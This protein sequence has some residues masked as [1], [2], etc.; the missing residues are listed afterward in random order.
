[1]PKLIDWSVRFDLMREAVVRLAASGGA[2]AV[3]LSAVAAELQVSASTL[4]RTLRSPDVLP[5]MGV[6]WIERQRRYPRFRGRPNGVEHGSIEHATWVISRELPTDEEEVD[7]ERAWR[8][9]TTLSASPRS[10]ELRDD[11]LAFLDNLVT[12]AIGLALPDGTSNELEVI[13][14]RALVD[15][16]TDAACRGSITG[17]QVL[18][19]LDRHMADLAEEAGSPLNPDVA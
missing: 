15:G 10:I 6:V 19:A 13:R 16:L 17:E 1:M 9:L 14:L 5:E 7:R 4:R 11:H 8:E 2:G 12:A 3:T 18:A